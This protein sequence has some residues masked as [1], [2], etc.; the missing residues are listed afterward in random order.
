M[1]NVDFHSIEEVDDISSKTEYKVA[2]EAGV[3]EE[4]AMEAVRLYSR[5]NAR[6]P[7]QWNGTRHGGFTT[8]T[9]WLKENPNY[10]QINVEEQ[11]EREDSVFQFYRSLITLRKNSD[12]EDSLIYGACIPYL[13]EQK[14]LMAYLRKGKVQTLLVMGNFQETP[15]KVKLPGV[16]EKVLINNMDGVDDRTEGEIGLRGWQYLVLEMS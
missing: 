5:D 11:K 15:Q 6:T 1:E 7:M 16:C 10:H 4:E 9:P 2:L 14:N 12:Y 13:R 8:G 3:S